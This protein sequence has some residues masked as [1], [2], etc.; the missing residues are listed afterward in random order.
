MIQD[1]E[2]E[3]LAGIEPLYGAGDFDG[4]DGK[5]ARELGSMDEHDE[6][7]SQVDSSDTPEVFRKQLETLKDPQAYARALA[8]GQIL[9][10]TPQQAKR[11]GNHTSDSDDYQ[12]LDAAKKQRVEQAFAAGKISMPILLRDE[13]TKQLWLL[14]G[15]TRLTY[16]GILGQ[17]IQAL[18]L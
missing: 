4:S 6:V 11:I 14:A 2:A 12:V 3:A 1:D 7:F 17:A 13:P 18:V 10:I 9:S 16:A 8:K 5:L 15:N